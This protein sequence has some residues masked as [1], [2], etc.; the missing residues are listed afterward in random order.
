[1]K[2]VLANESAYRCGAAEAAGAN[3]RRI[4]C[5]LVDAR[6]MSESIDASG[7]TASGGKPAARAASLD[8]GPIASTSGFSRVRRSRARYVARPRPSR[9]TGKSRRAARARGRHRRREVRS[10]RRPSRA[11]PL[12]SGWG[13]L[14]CAAAGRPCRPSARRCRPARVR[15]PTP[16]PRRR[17][18]MRP[19]ARDER[20]RSRIPARTRRA[21]RACR[22]R[23]SRECRPVRCS[24]CAARAA[25]RVRSARTIRMRRRSPRRAESRRA[26]RRRREPRWRARLVRPPARASRGKT[27][28]YASRER[29]AGS[30]RP[31][32]ARSRR[33]RRRAVCADACRRCRESVRSAD[34][35]AAPPAGVRAGGLD[36]PTRAPAGSDSNVAKS[37]AAER[38]AR[39]FARGDRGDAACR[40]RVRSADPCTSAPRSRR[41]PRAARFRV[42]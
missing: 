40:R 39:I 8:S 30:T 9:S 41:A 32:P 29:A 18:R 19:P 17:R 6:R 33:T 15:V 7:A 4:G 31:S 14:A 24:P 42:L 34:R 37:L 21:L 11:A 10:P 35:G 22:L 20:E 12:R 28:R 27:L 5:S 16:A 25:R 38:V 3:H 36:V 23:A 1:M 26:R 2:P 13:V